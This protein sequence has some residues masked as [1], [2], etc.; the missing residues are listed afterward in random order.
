MPARPV[1]AAYII[2]NPRGVIYVGATRDLVQRVADHNRGHASDFTRHHGG[3]WALVHVRPVPTFRAA[4]R[5]E[6]H[7]TRTL[8]R[9]G[10][11]RGLKERP[12]A[13]GPPFHPDHVMPAAEVALVMAAAAALCEDLP[14]GS[15]PAGFGAPAA[16]SSACP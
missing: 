4:Q 7:W 3:P 15:E 16:P 11:L 6:A 2:R 13:W 8:H 5:L 9:T 10:T 12:T 1:V 14:A